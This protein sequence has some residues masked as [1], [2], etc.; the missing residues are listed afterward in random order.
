VTTFSRA[1]DLR[2][3]GGAE[4]EHE[5]ELLRLA[6][7]GDRAALGHLYQRHVDAVYAYIRCRVAEDDAAE[8][9][10]Q[11]VF[12]SAVRGLHRFRWESG[13]APW[14]MRIAHNRVANHWR[15]ASRRPALV[16]LPDDDGADVGV[17]DSLAAD[18]PEIDPLAIAVRAEDLHSALDAL[19]ELQREVIALR[20]AGGL[21]LRETADVM[22][23]SV[24]AIKNLQHKA[25]GALKRELAARGVA[26]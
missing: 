17:P 8:D 24:N 18:E 10:T 2:G 11:D 19:T 3:F 15:S 4:D 14:L 22:G 12:M 25:L 16:E 13:M 6:Q 20:F 26:A 23:R 5:Q 7:A 21:S 9:L 1:A